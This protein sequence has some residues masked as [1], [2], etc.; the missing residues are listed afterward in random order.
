MTAATELTAT[1]R[2]IIGKA[3]KRLA[4]QG[5]IP[6]VI[7]GHKREP[8]AV[9][10]DKHDFEQ[11]M[12]HH[13]GATLVEV[14]LEG[15]KKPINAM[16]REIQRSPVKGN[17]LHVDL[18]AVSMTQKVS[19]AIPLHLVNDPEGVKAGGILTVNLHE[20]NVEGL[21]GDLPEGIEWDVAALEVGDT[22]TVGE[23]V[24]P[25]GLTLLD[26]PEAIVASVQAPRLEVEE[27]AEEA[28]EGAE[29][30]LIGAKEET[31]E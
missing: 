25:E 16:I 3:S 23:I 2:Q 5:Q 18:V 11:F 22:L 15:E 9:A 24:P 7:Y 6:A 17:I 29:P 21:P 30:E 19:A 14:M 13:A 31:E 27:E 28:E 20:L 26:D 10:V 1:P 4:G 12:A 8:M